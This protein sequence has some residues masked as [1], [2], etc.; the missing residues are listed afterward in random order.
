MTNLLFS[1]QFGDTV[2]PLIYD[3]FV[4]HLIFIN[5]LCKCGALVIYDKISKYDFWGTVFPLIYSFLYTLGYFS[6]SFMANLIII[7]YYFGPQSS[8]RTGISF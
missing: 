3:E 1:I 8:T 7:I 5:F 4:I 6:Q 2:F